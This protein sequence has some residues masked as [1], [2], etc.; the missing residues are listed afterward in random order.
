M[1]KKMDNSTLKAMLAS[2]RADALAAVAASKLSKER[3]D[4]L[5]YYMG[6]MKIGR[7]HV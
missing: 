2:E 7:A 3:A 6:D 5:D 1:P 4:A